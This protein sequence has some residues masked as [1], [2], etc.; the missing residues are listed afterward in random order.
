[1]ASIDG[2]ISG[3]STT[4][5]I[6]Q[7]MQVEAAPQTALKT[8][9][10]TANK[11]VTAYQSVNSRLSSLVTAANAVGSSNTW[12]GMKATSSSAA[13]VVTA[14]PGAGA[15]SL[16]FRV[17]KLATTHTMT[18][19]ADS[20]SSAT[21]PDVT[22]P[23]MLGSSFTIALSPTDTRT[24]TPENKS[25]QSVAAAINKEAGLP[26]K[27][28]AVQ[29]GPGEYTLQ[30]TA[31]T[32]GDAAKFDAAKLPSGLELGS[33]SATV[34]GVDAELKVGT[35]ATYT[36]KSATNTFTDVLPGVTVTA[37]KKQEVGEAAVTIGVTNDADGIAA[38]VQAL[39]DN[40]NVV[41][42]EIA[43]QNK[44]KNGTV[45]A[46]PL[47]GD[48][49]MRKLTQD[50]IGAV[51]GGASGL[52]SNNGTASFNQVGVSVDRSGKLTFNQ[53]EFLKSYNADPA[54]TQKFF[55]QKV[56]KPGGTA[57]KFDPGFD[58]AVGLGRKLEAVALIASV[59][60]SDPLDSTKAKQGTMQALIERN[61]ATI[62]GLDAQVSAWD[63]RLDMRKTA[64]QKQ[65]SSLEVALGKMQQQSTWLASQL[66]GLS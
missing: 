19:A 26:Y 28:A 17:E 3:M 46:G 21:D 53:A 58:T 13:A 36:I 23:V 2:L 51:T 40:A 66:A 60:V 9:I 45:A 48:S 31:K 29:I 62:K 11:V 33:A 7:L 39:V 65:F 63:I 41:L 42:S 47:V 43:S 32:S 57:D 25:L 50:I 14:A 20:V 30:L 1:M 27:A 15:G 18:F 55:D 12:G 59:G 4:D 34:I 38:K 16:S 35:D 10:T 64:L 24:I 37:A 61:T 22:P 56:D 5:T 52:G 54:A 49:A 6:N 44:I 8:K